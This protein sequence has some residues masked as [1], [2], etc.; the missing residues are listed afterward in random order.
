MIALEL[1]Q[2]YPKAGEA[3]VKY[4]SEIF[5]K[6]IENTNV[7]E[8]FKEFARQQQID[9]QYVADFIDNNPRGTFDVFDAN[10]VYIEIL[11]GYK[12][13]PL[14]NYIINGDVEGN[15]EAILYDTRKEAEIGAVEKAFEILNNK[16]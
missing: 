15:V 10:S 9:D 11:I 7:P 1:I 13:K 3:V 4:Y 6:S 8:E 12:P 5:A 14:F 16:L 2:K